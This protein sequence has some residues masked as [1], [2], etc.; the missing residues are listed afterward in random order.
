[1]RCN[2]VFASFRFR[3]WALP[4]SKAQHRYDPDPP[5]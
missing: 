1:M 3:R 4:I 2:E 5:C